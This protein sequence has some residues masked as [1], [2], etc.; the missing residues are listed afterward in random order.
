MNSELARIYIRKFKSTDDATAFIH[1]AKV[2]NER[3]SAVDVRYRLYHPQ[4]DPTTLYKIWEYP[5]D[6][7]MKWVQSSMEGV[8]GLPHALAA[9][10][11]VF[12]AD[13]AWAFDCEE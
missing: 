5:D 7:S 3:I 6:D 9:E 2:V 8:T 10:T 12:T 11:N 13:V 4:E 1:V